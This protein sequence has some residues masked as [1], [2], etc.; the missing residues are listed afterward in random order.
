MASVRDLKKD[1]NYVFGDII[2]AAGLWEITHSDKDT[3]KSEEIIEK[4]IEAFD[5]LRAKVNQK[6]VANK[7]SHFKAIRAELYERAQNLVDQVNS[8]YD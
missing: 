6:A 5:E 2:D 8:L 7:K 4:A 3:K 1:I